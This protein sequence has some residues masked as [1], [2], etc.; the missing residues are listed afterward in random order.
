M[1]HTPDRERLARKPRS[2]RR[3]RPVRKAPP[4]GTEVP[5]VLVRLLARQAA[6]ETLAFPPPDTSPTVNRLPNEE[7][8]S[9]A[10]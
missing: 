10:D 4:A 9:D 6:R 8:P 7:G 1:G 2:E 5:I 3:P